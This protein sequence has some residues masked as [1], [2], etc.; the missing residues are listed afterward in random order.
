MR[1]ALPPV[2]PRPASA[3]LGAG[4]AS[5]PPC[6]APPAR[7]RWPWRRGCQ[8]PAAAPRRPA[9]H[10]PRARPASRSSATGPPNLPCPLHLHLPPARSTPQDRVFDVSFNAL[11]GPFPAFIYKY[12]PQ[13]NERCGCQVT[14]NTSGPDMKLLCPT[15]F[16][17][18]D[19]A[20]LGK[21]LA[22]SKLECVGTDGNT[23]D[24]NA[25][26]LTGELRAPGSA[27]SSGANRNVIIAVV[28]SL[29]AAAVL[30]VA[31]FFALRKVRE[32]RRARSFQSMK[33]TAE[34]VNPLELTPESQQV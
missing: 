19:K 16:N 29:L 3:G 17:V 34:P 18:T 1:P 21:A 13:V 2:P 31:G 33:D 4:A 27:G 8:R 28:V 22:T 24:L 11:S 15:S 23:Y 26:L 25:L 9:R 30:G 6:P 32:E 7:L 14:V 12:L 10:L 5:G 20:S